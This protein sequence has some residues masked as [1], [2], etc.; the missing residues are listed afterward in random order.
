M[1]ISVLKTAAEH[2]RALEELFLWAERVDL[3]CAWANSSAGGASHWRLIDLDKIGKAVIGDQFAQTEPWVLRE[4][5]AREKLRIGRAEG[6]FH[7]KLYLGYRGKKARAIVGSANLTAA[8]FSYNVELGVLLDGLST[9]SE[10]GELRAFHRAQWKRAEEIDSDWIDSYELEWKF[11]PFVRRAKWVLESVDD[12]RMSWPQ[13]Y[14]LL[15]SQED[16]MPVIRVFQ[17]APSYEHELSHVQAIFHRHRKFSGASLEHRRSLLGLRGYSSGLIGSMDAAVTAKG[18]IR[19]EPE[20]I[21]KYLDLI[22]LRGDLPAVL[23]DDVVRGLL[24]V[25]G[26]KLAVAT[27][28]LAAKR[29]DVFVSANKGSKHGLIRLLGKKRLS[30]ADDYL[31][32]LEAIGQLEWYR[33]PSPVAGLQEQRAWRW[34]AALLD[35]VLYRPVN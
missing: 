27:R 20:K 18:V 2:R 3:A 22:P 4:L 21:G 31:Q 13:Y 32:L 14:R 17:A 30:T 9:E 12:L 5:L 29:P 35:S 26:V 28:L 6:I 34:R 23:V 7:P 16:R 24:A 8:A 11:R 1:K 15:L 10:F 25:G 19:D 33:S